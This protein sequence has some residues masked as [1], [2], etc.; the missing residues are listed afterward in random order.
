MRRRVRQ[1][2]K[3]VIIALCLA[4]VGCPSSREPQICSEFFN[5][6]ARQDVRVFREYELS[7]QLVIHT[8]GLTRHP[9]TDYSEIIASR[10]DTIVPA[11]LVAMESWNGKSTYDADLSKYAIIL[12]FERLAAKGKLSTNPNVIARIEKSAFEIRT[13]WVREEVS[14]AIVSIREQTGHASA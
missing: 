2:A 14:K 6:K 9:P 13:K 7:T 11:L 4:Q 10:G 8:C 5:S 1:S 12:V 3:L